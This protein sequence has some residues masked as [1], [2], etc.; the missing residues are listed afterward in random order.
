MP[1]C[2]FCAAPV[3]DPPCS[4]CRVLIS[5]GDVDA[6]ARRAIANFSA[7]QAATGLSAPDLLDRLRRLLLDDPG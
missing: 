6:L 5:V 1:T 2:P 3:A 7:L 4:A